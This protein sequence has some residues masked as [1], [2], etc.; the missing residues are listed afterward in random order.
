MQGSIDFQRSNAEGGSDSYLYA[1]FEDFY[2]EILRNK[3]KVLAK[4]WLQPDATGQTS[5]PDFFASQLLEKFEV[6]FDTQESEIFGHSLMSTMHSLYTEIKYAMVVLTDEIFLNIDWPAHQYWEDH[7]LEQ[8]IYGTHSGGQVFFKKIDELLIRENPTWRI[9]EQ[10][11]LAVLGLG[12]RG[13]FLTSDNSEE[14][15]AYA[16]RLFDFINNKKPGLLTTQTF[17][18]SPQATQETLSGLR[19]KNLP[20]I[21]NW[22]IAFTVIGLLYLAISYMV[23]YYSTESINALADR[24]I[25]NNFTK[26]GDGS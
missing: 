23:W 4:T 5:T 6:Y 13:K 1:C 10:V 24:V 9:L 25:L 17:E 19:A 14:L 20:D 22:Y 8:R 16:D 26:L 21:R 15:Q 12:F 11:Y 3:Q 7:L 18:L 2:C